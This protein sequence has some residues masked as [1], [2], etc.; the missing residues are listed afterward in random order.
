MNVF[1][2][3]VDVAMEQEEVFEDWVNNVFRGAELAVFGACIG[4]L[5]I[6]RGVSPVE[7]AHGIPERHGDV[8]MARV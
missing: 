5:V 1:E 6:D 8:P 2:S 4:G 3:I 7:L